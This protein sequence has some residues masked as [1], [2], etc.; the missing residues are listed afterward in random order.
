MGYLNQP[1]LT[2]AAFTPDGFF[3]TGD[4]GHEK[5]GFFYVTD[6]IKELIKYKGFQVAPAELEAILLEHPKVND[7]AVIGV[8]SD[9]HAS[10][11]P[12][13]YVVVAPGV[14]QDEGTRREVQDFVHARVA[15]H[16]RL[17]GGIRFVAEVPKSSSGKILRR[18]LKAE[19]NAEAEK[20][21]AKL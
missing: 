5:D 4:I 15:A 14:A 17:R 1:E 18:I 9:E 7:A 2:K 12:R 8:H 16:K 11:L 19:A 3:K 10:E 21:K 20:A 6:R 13:A